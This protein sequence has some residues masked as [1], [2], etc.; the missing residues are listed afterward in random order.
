MKR[1]SREAAGLRRD[2]LLPW[3]L[4]LCLCALLAAV[5]R[6]YQSPG[7]DLP[8]DT[9]IDEDRWAMLRAA[10]QPAREVQAL[11]ITSADEESQQV[12]RQVGFVLD[13]LG[14]GASVRQVGLAG[15]DAALPGDDGSEG[16]VPPPVATPT[17]ITRGAERIRLMILCESDLA[18]LNLDTEALSAWVAGGGQLMLA[19]GLDSAALPEAWENLLGLAHQAEYP[20]LQVESMRLQSS[21]LAGGQGMEFSDEV[22]LCQMSQVQL[23]PEALAHITTADEAASPLLW[24][25]PFGRGTVLVCGVD[26][27]DSKASRGLICSCIAR[28]QDVT[29]WPVINAAVYCIDDFP[30]AAPAG[31][32]RN[33]RE[34]FGCTVADFYNNI[35]WPAIRR[36]GRQYR[37]PYSCFLIQCYDAD[38][39][40]PFDNDSHWKSAAYF[41]RL[42]LEDGGEIGI[43]GYNHQPLVLQGYTY[44][45]KNSGYLPWPSN[46]RMVESIR[47]LTE[48]AA[49]LSPDI[50]LQAY[51]APSNVLDENGLAVLTEHFEDLRIF[52]GVYIG[53]P[54]QMVQEFAVLEDGVVTVPRLTADMQMEDSE[55]W[56]QLNALN[57]HFAESNYIHPDDIL[58]EERNDGGD[59][60]AM[61]EGYEHMVRWNQEHHLR[62]STISQAAGAVQRCCNLSVERREDADGITLRLSGFIDEASLLLRLRDADRL[63]VCSEGGRLTRIDE[64]LWLLEADEPQLRIEWEAVP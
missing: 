28:L 51:V 12:C 30:S 8:A 14:I 32:D 21:L 26:L 20:P 22:I 10:H 50:R 60:S 47:A 23:R 29:V 55:W 15:D 62:A 45:E 41:A 34:Q 63:P 33:V 40:G 16:E 2:L 9:L 1:A 37:L 24:E 53:T 42:I 58:D 3:L 61:L 64:G 11:L 6:G 39:D 31:Y 57:F 56:M 43:H 25:L 18:I 4:L 19:G 7:A 38:T 5:Q 27:M 54:D 48:Y 49:R 46:F 13:T 35:W 52:A 17:D 59:F 36:I 44:D